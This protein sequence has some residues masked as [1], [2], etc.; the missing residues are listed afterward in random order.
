[1]DNSL[2]SLLHK[3]DTAS[4]VSLIQYN[5]GQF[6]VLQFLDDE[7]AISYDNLLDLEKT[8]EYVQISAR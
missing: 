3:L 1:M 7:S 6:G 8:I 2:G 4:Q 5:M